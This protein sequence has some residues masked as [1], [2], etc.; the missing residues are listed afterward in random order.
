LVLQNKNIYNIIPNK[1]YFVK[2][3]GKGCD[4]IKEKNIKKEVELCPEFVSLI[5]NIKKESNARRKCCATA[6]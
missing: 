5:M 6:V 4:T 1:Y 2:T 3:K